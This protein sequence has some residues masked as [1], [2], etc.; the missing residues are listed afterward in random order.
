MGA[1]EGNGIVLAELWSFPR[2]LHPRKYL[3][4]CESLMT[5]LVSE[6]NFHQGG[7][8]VGMIMMCSLCTS[9]CLGDKVSVQ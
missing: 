9:A 8:G 4:Y 6:M 5:H 1:E 7:G 2:L 3:V